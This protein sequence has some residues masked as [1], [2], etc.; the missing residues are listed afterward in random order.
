L[1]KAQG[2]VSMKLNSLAWVLPK[3]QITGHTYALKNSWGLF[4]GGDINAKSAIDNICNNIASAFG[5]SCPNMAVEF[6]M[7]VTSS[8]LGFQFKIVGQTV[9]CK[10]V[11]SPFSF[12][13]GVQGSF[14]G[15]SFN[16]N[17][18]GRRRLAA[19]RRAVPLASDYDLQDPDG[20]DVVEIVCEGELTGI[21]RVH[22]KNTHTRVGEPMVKG[23]PAKEADL[24]KHVHELGPEAEKHFK[25]ILE[26]KALMLEN[27]P[28]D[29]ELEELKQYYPDTDATGDEDDDEES[30]DDDEEDEDD[31]SEE[32][33]ELPDLVH[34]PGDDLL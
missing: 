18:W 12:T 20:Y 31:E 27:E 21:V 11:Y 29:E 30:S 19:N 32:D 5:L 8:N 10:L 28:T 24:E 2:A 15:W 4:L 16:Y 13:C 22:G 1:M 34:L 6:E 9:T 3:L 17:I 7:W 26:F 25:P 33:D 23:R 14:L